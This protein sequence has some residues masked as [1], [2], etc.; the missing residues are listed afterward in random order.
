[1]KPN[2][3]NNLLDRCQGQIVVVVAVSLVVLIAM[4][5][6][7]IDSGRGYGV[8]AKLSS[9]VDAASIAAARALS[10]GATDADRIVAANAAALKFYNANF[11]DDYLGATRNPPTVVAAPNTPDFGKWTVTVQGSA[12]M[13]VTF[14]KV[15]GIT[16][17]IEVG[18]S[19]KTIKRD[20]DV[21][22]VLDTSGSLANPSSALPTL[23][24][25]ATTCFVNKFTAGAGGDRVGFVSF[26]SG[27]QLNV[28]INKNATRGF[29]KTAVTNAINGLPGASGSTA[30]AE[31]MRIALEDIDAIPSGILRSSLRVIVFFSD[32]APNDVSATFSPSKGVPLAG[33]LYSETSGPATTRANNLYRNDLRDQLLRSFDTTTTGTVGYIQTLPNLGLGNPAV[34]LNGKRTLDRVSTSDPAYPALINTRCNVNKAARNMIENVANRARGEN[35]MIYTVGVGDAL[36]SNEINFCGYGPVE[37]GANILNRLSN[38]ATSDTYDSSQP[39]GM[40]LHATDMSGVCAAFSS[41]ASQILRLY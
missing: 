32:G 35:I 31:G 14:L 17:P 16:E 22:L 29:D 37:Y 3:P 5:G 36:N 20:V 18:A 4:I 25:A 34:P 23:K 1:M 10:Q 24:T 19:G 12:D 21:M 8:K 28:P 33:D 9:A 7:A 38:S 30:Q 39:A 27:A 11:P 41:I 15:L 13:P 40:Y 26:A 2:S 6:L